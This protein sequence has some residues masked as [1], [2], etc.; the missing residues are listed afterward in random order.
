MMDKA[1]D[2]ISYRLLSEY[3]QKKMFDF[4]ADS[5]FGDASGRQY[6]RINY[7]GGSAILM[8]VADVKPGEFGRG[9]SFFDF[10]AIRDLFQ[11]CGINVPKVFSIAEDQKAL[12]LEDLGDITMFKMVESDRKNKLKY[13]KSAVELLAKMQE[14]LYNRER[15]D[16]PAEKRI[17]SN[18]LFMDEFYHFYEYMIAK[19]VY[20]KPFNH[21]WPKLEKKFKKISNELSKTPYFF[22]HRDFQ[23]KNIMIKD[24]SS[25]LIDFQDALMAPAV[26]DLVSLLRDSYI[27][28][29]DEEVET[30]LKYFWKINKV[31]KELFSDY[32]SFERVFYLQTLQRKMKDAGRF[33]YLN[34]V[35]GKEWFIQYVVPTLGYVK[36]TIIKLEMEELL[37][38]LGPY[39][40]ELFP[41]E[42]K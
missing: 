6:F 2:F 11:E 16:S 9:D 13:I 32:E 42:K 40:P 12:L 30:M 3:K 22:T 10:I 33:I 39:I 1:I 26:Y 7:I 36:S 23:S 15:F 8:K 38:L 27:V 24:G 31:S 5:L 20:D 18:S 17:F 37:D 21:L 28:L 41:G 35:K 34:Q 14:S 19:R 29:T 25:Y 4:T